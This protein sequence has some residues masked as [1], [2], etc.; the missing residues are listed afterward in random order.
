MKAEELNDILIKK[1]E[2]KIE[3]KDVCVLKQPDKNDN[4]RYERGR[5]NASYEQE[6][7]QAHRQE[8]YHG[9]QIRNHTKTAGVQLWRREAFSEDSMKRGRQRRGE[10]SGNVRGRGQI[11]L[12]VWK[13]QKT[14]SCPVKRETP[15]KIDVT[16]VI[17]LHSIVCGGACLCL[18]RDQYWH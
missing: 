7:W 4:L 1:H 16:D 15:N 12:D 13:R 8:E 5:L 10:A 9:C 17:G 18:Q 14:T 11:K 3:S 2:Q 6:Q